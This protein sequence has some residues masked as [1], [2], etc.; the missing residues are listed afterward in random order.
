MIRTRMSAAF[1]V[2]DRFAQNGTFGPFASITSTFTKKGVR[3]YRLQGETGKYS[4]FSE[5][6]LQRT[7]Y[8]VDR[9]RRARYRLVRV[10]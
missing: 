9:P 6:K 10:S 1:K 7:C 3:Y 5:E 4:T 2:G 8:Q